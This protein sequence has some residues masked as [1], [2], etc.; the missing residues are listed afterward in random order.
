MVQMQV[1]LDLKLPILSGASQRRVLQEVQRQATIETRARLLKPWRP[2]IPVLTGRTRQSLR[3]QKPRRAYER[4]Y[5]VGARV[6][7][8]PTLHLLRPY[9]QFRRDIDALS[10]EILP[11]ILADVLL[12]ERRRYG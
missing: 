11:R 6:R 5:F 2:R 3:A 8:R 10:P 9:R 12:E 4:G 7:Y 1:E